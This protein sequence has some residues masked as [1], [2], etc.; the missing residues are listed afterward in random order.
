MHSKNLGNLCYD[1]NCFESV[2]LNDTEGFIFNSSNH[3]II[4]NEKFC[5]GL[6]FAIPQKTLFFPD[7]LLCFELLHRSIFLD[8]P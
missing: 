4:V 1:D 5:K 8:I 2:T 3:T 7:Y 6:N